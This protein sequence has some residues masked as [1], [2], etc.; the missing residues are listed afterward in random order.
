MLEI[1]FESQ[2]TLSEYLKNESRKEREKGRRDGRRREMM[3]AIANGEE[4]AEGEGRENGSSFKPTV[5][6][7]GNPKISSKTGCF[8]DIRRDISHR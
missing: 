4:R 7:S 8:C 2:K 5:S 6:Y 1:G 3:M